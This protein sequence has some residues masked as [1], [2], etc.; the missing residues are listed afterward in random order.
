MQADARSHDRA[1][2]AEF[3]E[4]DSA[5]LS[6]LVSLYKNRIAF[7][8]GTAAT[9]AGITASTATGSAELEFQPL[10]YNTEKITSVMGSAAG[11]G[12]AA[13]AATSSSSGAGAG[14]DLRGPSGPAP[15]QITALTEAQMPDGLD[16]AVWE[17]FV[18]YRAA[19]GQMD[20]ALREQ[21]AQVSFG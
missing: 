12:A 17:K 1:L 21:A 8:P 14:I 10:S 11:G 6:K 3:A 4:A 18:E 5:A 19:R 15:I 13:A 9:A 16:A 20:I 7:A 2:K